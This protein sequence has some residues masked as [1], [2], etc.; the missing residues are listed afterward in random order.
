[1]VPFTGDV[2]SF[3]ATIYGGLII[4]LLFDINRSLKSNFKILKYFSIYNVKISFIILILSAFTAPVIDILFFNS[5][6]LNFLKN[7]D[8]CLELSKQGTFLSNSD[9]YRPT[10]GEK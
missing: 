7:D 9:Y 10:Y 5:S 6:I 3:Y 1:M 8:T 4:G 2:S